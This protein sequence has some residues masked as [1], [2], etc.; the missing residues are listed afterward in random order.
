[1]F[2]PRP[3]GFWS[4]HSSSTKHQILTVGLRYRVQKEFEDF[5]RDRHL[6][7]EEWV[8]LGHSFLPYE[9]G[10]SFFVS[11]DGAQEWHIRLQWRPE[12]QGAVLDALDEYLQPI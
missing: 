3:A 8:F 4:G 7:G 2:G 11:L 9:D 1:M 10:M 12:Q 5:D 6:I